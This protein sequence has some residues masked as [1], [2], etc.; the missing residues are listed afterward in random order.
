MLVVGLGAIG[1]ELARLARALGLRVIG[2]RRSPRRDDDPVDELV[3]PEA[4]HEALP[5]AD[6][7]ALACPL[8][9]KTR[10]MIDARALALLPRGARILNV[11]RGEVI[12]ELAL[13]EALRTGHLAGA[14]LD[15]FAVE[16]LPAD[17]PLWDMPGVMISPHDSSPSEGNLTRQAEVFLRNLAHWRRGEA[18]ENEV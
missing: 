18:L 12:D 8:T 4:L 14:Y 5:R 9:E 16:P 2:A 3:S 15:V 13:I 17:S 11:S 6:W 1:A 10:G 7:L